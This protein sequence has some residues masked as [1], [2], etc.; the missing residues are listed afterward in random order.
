MY[1]PCSG[2]YLYRRERKK[3]HRK[4]SDKINESLKARRR[5]GGGSSSDEVS[6]ESQSQQEVEDETDEEEEEDEED[7]EEEDD[8]DDDENGSTSEGESSVDLDDERMPLE[9]G[10]VLK[11]ALELDFE[12]ITRRNK[13]LFV[14]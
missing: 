3:R 10:D 2:A 12:L 7:E 13:V 5:A 11:K 9:L 4:L 6:S 1:L 14:Y 8:D